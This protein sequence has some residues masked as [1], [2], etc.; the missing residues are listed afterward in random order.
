MFKEYIGK[1]KASIGEENTTH[2]L[3]NNIFLLVAGSNDLANTY[4]TLKLRSFQYDILSYAD[5]LVAS[6]SDF[7][8]VNGYKYVLCFR[9]ESCCEG[10][11]FRQS[12]R[13]LV[14]QF[15]DVLLA[16]VR[17]KSPPEVY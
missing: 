14:H 16:F 13:S 8:Q 4:F 10:V 17:V 5:L 7:I 2:V 15:A 12:V 9:D 6:A 1:L 11:C 3:N